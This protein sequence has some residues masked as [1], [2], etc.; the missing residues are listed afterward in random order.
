MNR[1]EKLSNRDTI[2]YEVDML[3]YCY[4]NLLHGKKRNPEG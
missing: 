1:P 3:E 2:I 4:K